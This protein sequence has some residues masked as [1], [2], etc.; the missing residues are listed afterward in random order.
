MTATAWP[1]R[2]HDDGIPTAPWMAGAPFPC[3]RDPELFFSDNPDEVT[4]AKRLCVNECSRRASCLQYAIEH[5]VP[6]GTWGGQSETERR[7]PA[8]PMFRCT[9]CG[10]EKDISHRRR[11][12]WCAACHKRWRLAGSP[13]SGPPAPKDHAAIR[14]DAEAARLAVAE[15]RFAS[16]AELRAGGA[17]NATA[18]LAV[19]V[20]KSQGSKYA[21]RLAAQSTA[22]TA[23]VIPELEA[24]A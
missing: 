14:A 16:Y 23:D 9:S 11:G 22:E 2:Q 12:E 5:R 3:R 7:T 10:D 18:S 13:E 1:E 6:F 4:E 20:S 15:E 19:G 8:P 17:D 21:R 24:T